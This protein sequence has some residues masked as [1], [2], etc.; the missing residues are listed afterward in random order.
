ML[1]RPGL[2]SDLAVAEACHAAGG[3]FDASRFRAK[4]GTLP[5]FYNVT[6]QDRFNS[7]RYRNKAEHAASLG[8]MDIAYIH[9]QDARKDFRDQWGA[10]DMKWLS[11]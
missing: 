9:P 5:P 6:G 11:R 2:G 3:L 4:Y 10:D 8:L 7:Y 1:R